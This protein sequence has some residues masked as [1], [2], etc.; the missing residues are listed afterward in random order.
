MTRVT[1]TPLARDDL[2][3]IG[4]YIARESQSRSVALRFLDSIGQ[5]LLLYAT[6]P[7]MGERRPDLGDDVR[8]FP[9]GNYVV[10]Y[11]PTEAGIE[12]LRVLHGNRDIPSAWR[13]RNG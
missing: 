7:E 6:Q 12:V 13:S 10:F 3:Q 11:R 4:R 1:R 2:K 8:Y 5:K 9:V